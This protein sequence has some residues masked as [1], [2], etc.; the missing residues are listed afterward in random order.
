M[1]ERIAAELR[2]D[3]LSTATE[4]RVLSSVSDIHDAILSAIEMYQH[5]RFYFNE[6]RT[7]TFLTT[8]LQA[9]YG[10]NDDTDIARI[11]KFD[12]VTATV[13][14]EPYE[15]TPMAPNEAEVAVSSGINRGQPEFYSYY[16]QEIVLAPIP[17]DDDWAIR[18]GAV[19][20]QPA[21]ASDSEANNVWMTK[22]ERLIRA[23]AKMELYL[24]VIKDIEAANTQK[25]IA[26]DALARLN[27]RMFNLAVMGDGLVEA[28][29]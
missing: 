18:V 2:R 1:K 29:G 3:D 17:V 20:S 28:W 12:Y 16:G 10:E 21:P 4:F 23:T 24:H 15:L 19:I 8:A 13:A 22:A 27:E 11:I 25:A 6:S 5:K 9:R 14:G 7:I 26:D